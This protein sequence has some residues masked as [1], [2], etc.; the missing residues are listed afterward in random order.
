M[1]EEEADKF[2]IGVAD[3]HDYFK[4]L[5]GKG[6]NSRRGKEI[7]RRFVS[8][9]LPNDEGGQEEGDEVGVL[10]EWVQPGHGEMTPA[11]EEA[12][13]KSNHVYMTLLDRFNAKGR[14]MNPTAGPTYAPAM[15]AKEPEAKLAKVSKAMLAD[16]QRRLFAEKKIRLDTVG[17]GARARRTIVRT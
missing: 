15:F 11:R 12:E 2:A 5:F 7:W 10:V 9:T 8:V 17:D 14:A 1:S 6:N 13:R 3:R 16:A 4:V